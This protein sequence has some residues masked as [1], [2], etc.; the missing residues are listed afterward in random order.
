M[1]MKP[2]FKDALV[3]ALSRGVAE[4]EGNWIMFNA[5]HLKGLENKW[6]NV[7]SCEQGLRPEFIRL[8]NAGSSVVSRFEDKISCHNAMVLAG[9]NR[10]V[11]EANIVRAW[12]ACKDG[13]QIIITGDKTAGISSLRKWVS[14]RAEIT[15]NFSKHHAVV[16]WFFKNGEQ[17]DLPELSRE[18]DGYYIS[19]GM[20]SSGGSDA[21]SK[22]LTEHFDKR[23][24]GPVADL[25]AGWGFLSNELLKRTSKVTE[26]DLFEADFLSLE[27]AKKNLKPYE[28][29]KPSFYWCDL[30]SEYKKKPYQWVIMNPPFHSSRSADPELGKRFI[31]VAA[32]TLPS[33][34]RLLM[35]A[36]RNLPYEDTLRKLFKH[37]K[38]LEE[39]DGFKVIEAVK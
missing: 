33:G 39:R 24:G 15:D 22:L 2:D 16:F 7:F 21:G 13:G 26:L 3:L 32:S 27:A 6:K 23:I 37:S 34:G 10:R 35:V 12:N 31:Q 25:G 29:L 30:T 8:E 9:R 18:I 14:Q 36:N 20:F 17:W 4:P 11:N 38:V 5:V 1:F 19:E 28:R